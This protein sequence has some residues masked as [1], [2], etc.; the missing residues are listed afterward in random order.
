MTDKR[1][2]LYW[3]GASRKDFKEFP[4]SVQKDL[5]VALFIVP[6]INLLTLQNPALPAFWFQNLG[7]KL[8][9]QDKILIVLKKYS[10]IVG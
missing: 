5:G 9:K 10:I 1:R 3:E 8:A 7:T 4:I 2:P 6:V